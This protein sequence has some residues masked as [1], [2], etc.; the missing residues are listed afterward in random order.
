M[1]KFGLLISLVLIAAA[2]NSP[3]PGQKG[4]KW[5]EKMAR[6]VMARNDSL[7]YY[8]GRTSIKWSYD[9]AMLGMAIDRLGGKDSV[10]SDYMKTYMD[11]FIRDDGS[12]RTYRRESYNLDNINPGR[13]L[14]T[15][16]QRDREQ[17]YRIAIETLAGQMKEHHRTHSGGF[18]HKQRYPWQMWLDGIYMASPFLAEYAAEFDQPE[19]FDTVAHQITL[20]YGKTLDTETGLLYH[21]WDESREQRWSDPETGQSPHFW[22]R[23]MGWY[24]MALVDV[25]DYL[26][27]DQPERDSI[28]GILQNCSDALMGVRDPASGAWFQVLDQGGREGNYLE[29]SGSAMYVYAF[30][31]GA[32]KGYLEERYTEIAEKAF[33]DL[34]R[35]FIIT[36]EDGM[37][38]LV[39][40]C[41]SCGLGG[42]PYRDGSYEYYINETIVKND[43][44]GVG[45][46]IL[47]AIELD[48]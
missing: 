18:W 9:D 40:I 29:A 47:A 42:D 12:I 34:L 5:S 10:F 41:G 35:A 11:C 1:K 17:K 30:A 48:R 24:M 4:E 27:E 26:P 13:N 37:I 16:Y 2:C 44:K 32:K 36:D 14:L 25:L 8:N 46:F 28:I 39:N 6:A 15:L 38:S 43:S 45:P 21:A 23:A 19:W 31:K 20:I 22:S 3:A 7:S 33:D